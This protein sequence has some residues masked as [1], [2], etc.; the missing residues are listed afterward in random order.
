MNQGLVESVRHSLEDETSENLLL[1]LKEHDRNRWSDEAFEAMKLVLVAR[2][3]ELPPQGDRTDRPAECDD[4]RS[5]KVDQHRW[6][7]AVVALGRC[8]GWAA[9]LAGAVLILVDYGQHRGYD[10]HICFLAILPR[11]LAMGITVVIALRDNLLPA[12][13]K[14]IVGALALSLTIFAIVEGS[15]ALRF[16]G[17]L[18]ILE[19]RDDLPLWLWNV[20]SIDGFRP[21]YHNA[22]AVSLIV[23]G[24]I[25]A[26]AIVA[27]WV[28][29][30][31]RKPYRA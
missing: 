6:I 22:A 28:G 26:L 30:V 27:A 10:L 31:M 1:Q 15:L 16:V 29:A 7:E 8:S 13:W 9:I 18:G 17:K 20:R 23:I 2:G 11:I 12:A 24:A 5:P 4:A 25:G 3:L 14:A 19:I 21:P